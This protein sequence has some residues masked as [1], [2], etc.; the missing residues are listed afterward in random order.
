[1]DDNFEQYLLQALLEALKE[2]DRL[3]VEL[4]FGFTGEGPKT[5]QRRIAWHRA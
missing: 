4:R 5:L 2:R 3:I 1:M